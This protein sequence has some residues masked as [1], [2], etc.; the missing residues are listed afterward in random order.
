MIDQMIGV[1]YILRGSWQPRNSELGGGHQGRLMG[2]QKTADLKMADRIWTF[3]RN[4]I[5]LCITGTEC[6][7]FLSLFLALVLIVLLDVLFYRATLV[8]LQLIN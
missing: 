8:V 5:L 1:G 7:V 2:A 3:W 6:T 4:E